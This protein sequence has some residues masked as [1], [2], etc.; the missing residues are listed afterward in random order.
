[1][2]TESRSGAI[3]K[4]PVKYEGIPA[5]RIIGTLTGNI[6]AS[7]DGESYT[8]GNDSYDSE[9]VPVTVMAKNDEYTLVC[10]EYLEERNM[11]WEYEYTYKII[12]GG[13]D[14][15][16]WVDNDKKG[17]LKIAVSRNSSEKEMPMS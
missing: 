13:S 11:M 2:T 6:E 15:W 12:E 9:G 17:S 7:A 16:L 8:V 5:D 14:R 1:M 4:V 10:V 3:A